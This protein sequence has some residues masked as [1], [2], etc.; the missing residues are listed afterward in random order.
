MDR[1]AF[2]AAIPLTLLAA[3][4]VTAG[5]AKPY[6]LALLIAGF[7]TATRA[8]DGGLEIR[9]DHGWKTYWRMPGDAG[10]PPQFDWAGSRNVKR[11]EVLWPA[12]RR[13]ADAGGETVG[14]K[15][16]VVFPLRIYPENPDKDVMLDLKLFFGVCQDICIPGNGS[17]SAHSGRADPAAAALIA[18]FAAKV[19]RPVEATS[20]FRAVTAGLADS[21]G[22]ALIL[23]MEGQV[24][25]AALDVF[26]EGADFAYFKMPRPAVE[27]SKL[28]IPFTTQG[29][30]AKLKG[31][32]LKL[33]MV[34][35]DLALE[36]D[37][38][39]E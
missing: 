17:I 31:R 30:P 15:D 35:P 28:I 2:V 7:D 3:P 38:T 37:V 16:R 39:V 12:P 32:R 27:P 11:V 1:R 21:D 36:Q 8:Y 13:F 20:P 6:K 25:H 5:L 4:N 10:I 18:S 9:L 34:A 23:A 22:P 19:P 26:V 33:T 24:D 14:Y 29:D